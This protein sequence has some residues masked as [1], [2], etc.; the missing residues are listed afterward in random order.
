MAGIAR[1]ENNGRSSE[2]TM[3]TWRI[4]IVDD[5]P[6]M[7]CFIRRVIQLCDFGT[8]EFL[9][10]GNGIDALASIDR[11]RPHIVLTDINM[12]LMNGEELLRTLTARQS[13]WRPPVV[14]VS[15]DSTQTRVGRMLELGAASYLKKPFAPEAM[16]QVLEDTRVLIDEGV[17]AE[18]GKET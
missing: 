14:V 11:D 2:G 3:K 9:E 5:S 12:P 16:R 13:G 15:T 17:G 6:A 8:C 4:L 7:R 1:T 10:A 18:T